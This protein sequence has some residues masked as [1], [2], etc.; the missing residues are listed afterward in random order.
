MQF[1]EARLHFGQAAQVLAQVVGELDA[2]APFLAV[3]HLAAGQLHHDVQGFVSRVIGQVGADA[4]GAADASG[5][6]L[7]DFERLVE[8]QGIAEDDGLGGGVDAELLVA[9]D[10]EV[11]KVELVARVTPHAVEQLR[12]LAAE[13]AE[14]GVRGVGIRQGGAQVSVVDVHPVLQGHVVGVLVA[15]LR[16]VKHEP[17]VRVGAHWLDVIFHGE[18]AV[19][20]A[21][22]VA[23]VLLQESVN[24]VLHLEGEASARAELGEEEAVGIGQLHFLLQPPDDQVGVGH[25]PQRFIEDFGHDGQQG[26]FV[27]GGLVEVVRH[28]DVQVAL[29]VQ[30]DV[31][32]LGVEAEGGEPLP[33]DAGEEAAMGGHV[34]QFFR[35]EGHLREVAD[36]GFQLL[37]EVVRVNGLIAVGEAERALRIRKQLDVGI[38]SG[39]LVEVCIQD[40]MNHIGLFLV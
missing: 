5:A 29:L 37:Q 14:E 38:R 9:F 10:E 32:P 15:E 28:L 26:H 12:L 33:V 27:E 20:G 39:E 31:H 7:L 36:G 17:F 8:V 6:V 23:G 40:G 25:A 30:A 21:R 24:L 3:A 1:I 13:V 35:R 22:A 4:E 2:L 18:V 11:G 16:A 19:G 34:L